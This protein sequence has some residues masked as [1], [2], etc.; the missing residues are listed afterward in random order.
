ME[1]HYEGP[2]FDE[3]CPRLNA[4]SQP[5]CSHSAGEHD[6]EGVC[7]ACVAAPGAQFRPCAKPMPEEWRGKDPILHL[8]GREIL[9][10]VKGSTEMI[11]GR[12]KDVESGIVI[13]EAIDDPMRVA[14]NGGSVARDKVENASLIQDSWRVGRKSRPPRM[15]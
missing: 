14:K 15:H 1:G 3:R 9:I 12:L 2:G 13:L 5:T 11:A 7:A 4:N 6:D 8:Q 10:N